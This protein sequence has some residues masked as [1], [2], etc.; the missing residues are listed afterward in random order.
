MSIYTIAGFS[1]VKEV[2][3]LLYPYL[4]LKKPTAKAVL[5]LIDYRA[6]TC[7]KSKDDFL[8]VC[9][10]VDKVSDFTDSK[11]RIITYEYVN[12]VFNSPVET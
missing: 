12:N 2:L 6:R 1:Q 4:R 10:L 7:V 8:E 9:K 5:K 3:L 11:K